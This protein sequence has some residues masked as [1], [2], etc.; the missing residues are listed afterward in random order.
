VPESFPEI[1][2]DSWFADAPVNTGRIYKNSLLCVN[3]V[4]LANRENAIQ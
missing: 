1:V 2:P 4:P 3:A